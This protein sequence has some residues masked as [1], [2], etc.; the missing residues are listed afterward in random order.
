MKHAK[1]WMPFLSEIASVITIS[2]LKAFIDVLIHTTGG[3]LMLLS[4]YVVMTKT[5][6]DLDGSLYEAISTDITFQS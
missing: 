6:G 2:A 4:Q 3:G 1:D 5:K